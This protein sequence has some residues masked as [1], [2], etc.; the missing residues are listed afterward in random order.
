M[1]GSAP[2]FISRITSGDP[3]SRVRRIIRPIFANG[4][5]GPDP[6]VGLFEVIAPSSIG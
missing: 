6:N 2:A 4:W 1:D 3:G 5:F